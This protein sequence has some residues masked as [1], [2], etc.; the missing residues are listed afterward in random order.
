MAKAIDGRRVA[1]QKLAPS[2]STNLG[3]WLDR[4]Q[5]GGDIR[6]RAVV[7][8]ACEI[9]DVPDGY[10]RAFARRVTA[11]DG[12]DGGVV[13]G[14]T[15][16]WTALATGRMVVG[17]GHASVRESGISLLRPW[18]LPF[19]PGSALKGVAASAARQQA[20]ERWRERGPGFAAL[21]GD[22]DGAGAVV[23]HDAWLEPGCAKPIALDVM[24][25]HHREY[26]GGDRQAPCDWDDPTPVSFV[27]AHGRYSIALSGPNKWVDAASALLEFGLR[28][29]GVGAKTAAGYGRL[30]RVVSKEEQAAARQA[31]DDARRVARLEERVQQLATLGVTPG[32][33][34][35]RVQE[36]F[37]ARAAGASA[38][39]VRA[40]ALAI[41]QSDP[42]MWKAWAKKPKTPLELRA[43][44]QDALGVSDI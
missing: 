38:A 9:I 3:L 19:I 1:L 10:G 35:Q 16:R 26:Y 11:L 30:E 4:H 13:G 44:M 12:F 6:V 27:T 14:T 39:T 22:A 29:L 32:D 8:G 34:R 21:F 28:E 24:T 41:W 31:D 42:R 43:L 20:D 36:L 33:A 37:D 18:G 17:L 25:V 7:T 23:F 2:A 15:R 40:A 5:A